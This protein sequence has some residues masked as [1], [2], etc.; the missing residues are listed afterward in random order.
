M[1]Q[2]VCNKADF[3]QHGFHAWRRVR[4]EVYSVWQAEKSGTK[5]GGCMDHLVRDM[6]ISEAAALI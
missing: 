4:I 2:D 3:K 6:Y 1:L 5:S